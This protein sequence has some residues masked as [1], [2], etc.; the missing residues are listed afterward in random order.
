MQKHPL[1]SIVIATKNE[2]KNI[3][4][5]L[6]SLSQQTYPYIELLLVDNHSSDKT[7]EIARRYTNNIYNLT[8]FI[9]LD[10]I[11]NHRGAQLN[12]GVKK[13][14]GEIIFFPDADM[15]F[16][17]KLIDEAVQELKIYDALY[18]QERI[19]GKGL[20]GKIRDFERSFYNQTC[21]DAIRIIKKDLFL[22]SGGFDEKNISFGPDDWDFT[23]RIK[24]KTSKITITESK[25]YHH[26][27]F[28]NVLSYITK[29]R[30]YTNTFKS[31]I[32]KWG[33]I[34]PDIKKQFGLYYRLLK[35][36]IEKGKWR[37]LISHPILSLGM[38]SLK[39]IIGLNFLIYRYTYE[40]YHR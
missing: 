19:I 20:F 37:R 25:I 35:V 7:R 40:K 33:P 13:A 28:P 10:N 11:K 2:E 26:E 15:T 14:S 18:I 8:D 22:Q 30:K 36:F 29:K 31:Y 23:K 27:Q 21:I 12:F 1:V 24:Q 17:K 32:D 9:K 3:A 16:D 39:L 34:D 38:F 4:S 6:A 5:C